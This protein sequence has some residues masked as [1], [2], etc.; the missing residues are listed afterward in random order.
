MAMIMKKFSYLN[1]VWKLLGFC[2]YCP[3][4]VCPVQEKQIFYCYHVEVILL[5][6]NIL[7][8]D[9]SSLRTANE[10]RS[11]ISKNWSYK[12]INAAAP[13]VVYRKWNLHEMNFENKVWNGLVYATF[14]P[15]QN[16]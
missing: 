5:V 14:P 7:V 3:A 15:L 9:L 11:S 8:Y 6:N 2:R 1:E 10:N 16:I 13:S 4:W 12:T